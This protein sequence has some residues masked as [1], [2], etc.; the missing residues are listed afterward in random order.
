VDNSKVVDDIFGLSLRESGYERII[1]LSEDN[2]YPNDTNSVDEK[3][4]QYRVPLT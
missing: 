2:E 4:C 1:S 3:A